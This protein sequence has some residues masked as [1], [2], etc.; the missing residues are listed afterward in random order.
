MRHYLIKNPRYLFFLLTSKYRQLKRCRWVE[1]YAG[2]A[3][4]VPC[5]IIYKIML[6]TKCNLSCRMCIN[7][8]DHD[9][10]KQPLSYE[11]IDFNLVEDLLLKTGS[12]SPSIILSGGEPFSYHKF[13]DLVLLIEKKKL[14]THICTNG[15]LLMEF[16]P[17]LKSTRYIHLIVSL[18][19]IKED[20]DL[21]RGDGVYDSV[22]DAIRKLRK[23]SKGIYIGIQ[24]TIMPENVS[25]MYQFC[26]DM[27]KLEV[28]WIL[29]NPCWFINDKQAEKY[30]AFIKKEY[31][32]EPRAH[33]GYMISYKPDTDAFAEQYN[34]IK[35]E[36]W[37]IQISCY[38]KDPINDLKKILIDD[39][40]FSGNSFCYKQWIRMDIMPDGKVVSCQQYPDITMGDL[41]KNEWFEIWNGEAFKSFRNKILE[42]PL[43]VCNKC[44]PVY[45]YD[46][47]RKRL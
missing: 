12:P 43:P 16:I 3:E 14:H 20:N 44:A 42:K 35:K 29:L 34:K 13:K 25:S 45:L 38:Y 2:T 23:E 47:K 46:R 1:K 37:P 19:G 28:D 22:V 41:N 36:K 10:H 32:A 9:N 5:P 4:V 17:L 39:S 27:V 31:G 11:E 15:T 40:Y 6:T 24:H 21:I 33:K 30:V 26:K 8:P 7:I 18:D